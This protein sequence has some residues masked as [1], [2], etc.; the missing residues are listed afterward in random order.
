MYNERVY[1]S[2]GATTAVG[3][4]DKPVLLERPRPPQYAKVDVSC[5]RAELSQFVLR[6]DVFGALSPFSR[7]FAFTVASENYQ[8]NTT[9]E[10]FQEAL[11]S[12]ESQPKPCPNTFCCHDVNKA[13]AVR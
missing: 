10:R 8:L 5:V 6:R 12:R 9:L 3:H 7:G 1:A 13:V 11:V 4:V 2:F